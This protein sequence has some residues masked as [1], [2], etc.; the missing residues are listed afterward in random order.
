MFVGVGQALNMA[1]ACKVQSPSVPWSSVL[2]GVLQAC[3]VPF[4]GSCASYTQGPDCTMLVH[5][6]QAVNV[7]PSSCFVC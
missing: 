4:V 7:S 5:V 2:M 1:V 3:Q 6:L